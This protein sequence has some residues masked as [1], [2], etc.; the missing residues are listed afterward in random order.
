[1]QSAQ[2]AGLRILSCFPDLWL[3]VSELVTR[4]KYITGSS[5]N[6]TSVDFMA[7]LSTSVATMSSHES[8][9]WVEATFWLDDRHGGMGVYIASKYSSVCLFNDIL[10]IPSQALH[11]D[12]I[13]QVVISNPIEFVCQNPHSN[14]FLQKIAGSLGCSNHFPTSFNGWCR[15]IYLFHTTLV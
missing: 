2:L 4:H 13:Q 15:A 3:C 14:R 1:M 8:R 9:Y 10:S 5:C 11:F 7:A 6:F 12:C